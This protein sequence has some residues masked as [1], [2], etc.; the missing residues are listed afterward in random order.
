MRD[1]DPRDEGSSQ[2]SAGRSVC[3]ARLR[4]SRQRY[5]FQFRSF[6]TFDLKLNVILWFSVVPILV[7]GFCGCAD[8]NKKSY[9]TISE[10]NVGVLRGY[11]RVCAN[12]DGGRRDAAATRLNR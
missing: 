6:L 10:I 8:I 11:T 12:Q 2:Y 3:S 5:Q 4:N 1:I 9:N 7:T